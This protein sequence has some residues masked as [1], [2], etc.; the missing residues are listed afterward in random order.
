MKSPSDEA[1][2]KLHR[3]TEAD[4]GDFMAN[5]EEGVGFI[6][7]GLA[8][9]KIQRERMARIAADRAMHLKR[10]AKDELTANVADSHVAR[11]VKVDGRSLRFG[12]G[13]EGFVT[14][15]FLPVAALR[16]CEQFRRDW[17]AANQGGA[18]AVID[19]MRVRVDTSVRNYESPGGRID[20]PKAFLAACAAIGGQRSV[21]VFVAV[22]CVAEGK[23]IKSAAALVA[24]RIGT[25]HPRKVTEMLVEAA[26]RLVEHYDPRP[27]YRTP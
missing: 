15:G 12:Y 17:E 27:A 21:E 19:P 25:K 7:E 8:R 9:L 11:V 14:R 4:L 22:H 6:G 23:T 2:P 16:A 18:I 10:P 5:D 13:I 26:R 3:M 20:A 1:V 24:E